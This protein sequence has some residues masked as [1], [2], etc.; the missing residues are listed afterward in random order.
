MSKVTEQ[1]WSLAE[2]VVFRNGCEIWDVEYLK[3][4]G[5]WFL[6]LYIDKPEGGVSINDCESISRELDKLLDEADPIAESYIFEVS[7]AGAERALK[8]PG[9][10]S[11]FMGANVEVK[12]YRPLDGAKA[13]TGK[14]TGYDNGDVIIETAAGELRLEK[15]QVA[16]VHLRID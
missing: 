2:P 16:S 5:Q 11:R 3:E 7:S 8:R 1:V 12:L 13:F 9:D 15:K 10:F 4:A 14:L 6:R